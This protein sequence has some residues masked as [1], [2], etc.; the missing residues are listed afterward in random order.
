MTEATFY[1]VWRTK[2]PERRAALIAKM[3]DEAP[4]LAAKPGFVS[5][6]VLEC[7]EDGRVL[8]EGRWQSKEAFDRAVTADPAAQKSRASLAEFGSPEPGLFKEALRVSP[9]HVGATVGEES[10]VAISPASII[11]TYVQVWRMR[12]T[13][14]QQRWLET[15]HSHIG[16]LTKQPGFISMSLHASLDGKQTAVYAQWENEASLTA[17]INLAEAKRSHDEMARWGTPDGSLYTV[18]AVFFPTSKSRQAHD[19]YPE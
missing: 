6:S 11:V 16:L 8:V 14:H 15:M 19:Q 17:A 7:A 3:K 2:T 5:M 9:E 12:A 13:G 10:R 18:D 1:N 4:T